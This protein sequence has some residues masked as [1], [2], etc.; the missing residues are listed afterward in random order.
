MAILT[1]LA[2]LARGGA[3]L[4][5]RLSCSPIT[6]HW[7]RQPITTHFVFW[8]VGLHQTRNKSSRLS[9]AGEKRGC[10]NVNYVK[11]NAIFEPPSMRACSCTPPKQNQDFVK[12][13]NSTPLKTES[14]K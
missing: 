12:E 1:E 2:V 6:T 13:H 4:K 7:D 8:K 5:R 10:N 11:N 14:M 9:Q 3:I